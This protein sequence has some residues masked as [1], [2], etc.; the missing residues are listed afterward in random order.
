MQKVVLV[1]DDEA[2]IRF[3]AVDVLEDDG[4]VVYEAGS[5]LE[6]V[7]ILSSR[8]IDVVFTDVTCPVA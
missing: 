3:V 1:V 4:Y 7:G 6:A 5:V 2:L 8:E